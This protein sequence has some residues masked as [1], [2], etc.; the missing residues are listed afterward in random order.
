MA[1]VLFCTG[2][3]TMESQNKQDWQRPIRVVKSNSWVCIRCPK[4]HTMIGIVQNLLELCQA[5]C[6]DCYSGD[7]APVPNH[8]LLFLIINQ[9]LTCQ[10]PS[11]NLASHVEKTQ[12]DPSVRQL[13]LKTWLDKNPR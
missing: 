3:F 6:C 10:S 8:C 7:P 9:H 11:S 2:C 12:L 1:S 5:W 13:L 4:N